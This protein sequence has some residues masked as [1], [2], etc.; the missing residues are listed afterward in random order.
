MADWLKGEITREEAEGATTAPPSIA[1]SPFN[2]AGHG[3]PPITQ[4]SKASFLL[5]QHAHIGGIASGTNE[6][7]S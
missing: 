6:T 5:T 2:Q 7:S 4:P 3:T 1:V